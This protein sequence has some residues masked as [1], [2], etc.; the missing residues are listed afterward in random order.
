MPEKNNRVKFAAKICAGLLMALVLVFSAA[1]ANA[2]TL[3][4]SPA[5]GS[6]R[7]GETFQVG[8][9]VS[10]PDQAMNACEAAISFPAD[11]LDVISVST[12]NSIFS[13]LVQPPNFSNG[14]GSTDF[15]GVVL[16]PGY[17]GASGRLVTI[18]FEAKAEGTAKVQI[19]S[20]RVLANDGNGTDIL[21]SYNGASFTI[22]PAKE[23]KAEAPPATSTPVNKPP[24]TPVPAKPAP[25]GASTTSVPAAV[26]TTSAAIATAMATPTENL[27]SQIE[28]ITITQ[29]ASKLPIIF[30]KIGALLIDPYIFLIIFLILLFIISAIISF[31]GF[32]RYYFP[33]KNRRK[34]KQ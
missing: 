26:S 34:R 1:L 4:F 7:V 14:S 28:E 3:H 10:S 6:Y 29:A 22:L 13:L 8:V 9:Y 12:K 11:K 24:Q 31:F 19:T 30:L 32:V 2:A 20:A 25:A 27:S 15:T 33:F 16:N 23:E 5:S 17:T 18:N 21:D